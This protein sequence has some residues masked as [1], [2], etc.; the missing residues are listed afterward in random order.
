M[1]ANLNFNLQHLL[2]HVPSCTLRSGCFVFSPIWLPKNCLILTG[3]F[4]HV[5][6]YATQSFRGNLPIQKQPFVALRTQALHDFNL[7][8]PFL[9]QQ[10]RAFCFVYLQP[11]AP[12]SPRVFRVIEKR[13]FEL[14]SYNSGFRHIAK[15]VLCFFSFVNGPIVSC[16][17]YRC[18]I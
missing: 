18:F 6:K 4:A 10:R 7:Q 2:P 14:S 13:D 1:A 17:K 15:R 16:E 11:L 9:F 12:T 3:C 8:C 5:P